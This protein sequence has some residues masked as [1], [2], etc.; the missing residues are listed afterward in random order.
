MSAAA[1]AIAPGFFDR[2]A[3]QRQPVNDLPRNVAKQLHLVESQSSDP[4]RVSSPRPE[5]YDVEKSMTSATQGRTIL[6]RAPIDNISE[7]EFARIVSNA[8]Q[9]HYG[10]LKASA[11]CVANDAGASVDAAKNWLSGLCPPSSV[12]LKRLE[13]KVPGLAAEIRR[14]QAMEADFDPNFQQQI[15]VLLTRM[16]RGCG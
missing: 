13:R 2:Q 7:R 16:Q 9:A 5:T 3:L 10:P 6:E 11:K 8:L 4:S 14:L 12:F 1:T 15:L